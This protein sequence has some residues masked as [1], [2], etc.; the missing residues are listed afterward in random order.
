MKRQ[1]K[2]SQ[3]FRILFLMIA[4]LVWASAASAQI[5]VHG[6][7]HDVHG[8]AIIGA[9][10][11]EHGTTNGTITDLDGNFSLTVKNDSK[12]QISYIGYETQVVNVQ[13]NLNITLSENNKELDEVV[14]IGYGAVK[15]SDATGS[16]ATLEADPKLKGV[17]TTA[18]DMLVGKIAGVNVVNGGGSAN[19]GSTIRI[20][21]GSSLSASNDPLIILDGVYLDNSG[22]GGVGNMLSTIDP[23]DIETFT[24][25][26]DAS[27]TAIYGSR[28]SNG[29]IIITTKK[30][31]A[32]K[33]KI[34]YD[35]NV[36]I[37]KVKKTIDV[38]D[39][40]EYRDFIRNTFKGA[41]N[42]AEVY[43]KAGLDPVTGD[44][45]YDYNTDWQD[46]IY[47]TAVSTEHNISVLGSVKEMMP[48]RVSLGFTDANGVQDGD[49]NRRYTGNIS[50]NPKFLNDRLKLNL[51][52][53]GMII[54]SDFAAGAIG[55]A[56]YYDPTKPIY[57]EGSPYLGYWSWTGIG[58]PY[59]REWGTSYNDAKNN[60]N[61]FG[62]GPNP[63][64]KID[65]NDN[66]ADVKNFIGSAQLEYNFKYVNG[67]KFNYNLS[68]DAS[69]SDGETVNVIGK[70]D[71]FAGSNM[72]DRNEWEQKRR[73]SQMDA[74]L[75]Y[76]HD[77]PSI[78]SKFDVMAGYSWQHYHVEGDS[79]YYAYTPIDPDG[80]LDADNQKFDNDLSNLT[81]NFY[82]NEHYIVSFFGRANYSYND[83][84]LLTFTLRDDGSS[85]FS[86]NNRWGLF[87]S[88]AFA[89]RV[90]QENFMENQNLFSNMKLR[91][92]WGKTGQQDINQGDYPFLST[93]SYS[94]STS[95][96]Y[97]RNGKWV[98][99][100]KPGAYNED[101]KWETT[102]TWNAGLDF[103]MFN[104]RLTA[105]LDYY[106]RETT[107]LINTEAK[108]PSGT[109]FA[110][111][112][113]SNIGTLTNTGVEITLGGM[114]IAKK[115]LQW[116]IDANLAFN[117]NEITKL[118]SGAEDTDVRRFE[119]TSDGDGATT[120]KAHAVNQHAG[121]FYVFQQVY[122]TDGKPIEGAYI[123]RNGDGS[124]NEGDLYFYHN[125]DPKM[126]FGISTKLQYKD[127]DFSI[128]G[129][130]SLGN[131]MYNGVAANSAA[132]APN[133]VY[134]VS[135]LTNKTKSAF[136][137]NFQE[138]QVLSDY[139]IQLASFFRIDNITLGY[140]FSNVFDKIGGRVYF[141]VQNPFVFTKYDGLD[142]EISGGVD[143]SFYPRPVTFLLGLNLNF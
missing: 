53:K 2:T 65:L 74:Y 45:L 135:A 142:P 143:N 64:S 55:N 89:W 10:V 129:H 9:T 13:P 78:K 121:M 114:P 125:A 127:F 16:V 139:Y 120:I 3:H 56:V 110:E 43:T 115:D 15:K 118:S 31:K 128:A 41:S 32:G 24:V 130:G 70:P 46:E 25:L 67:L 132:L 57:A 99:L 21:G 80:A 62:A 22:I 11:V 75:T 97:Y 100:L 138:A 119:R 77:L 29:V 12:I 51:N 106:Y 7:V 95:A 30:G 37:S 123:D 82:E 105:S 116:R 137:T 54:H 81:M 60:Y 63:V 103:G 141:T 90:S 104:D 107:D 136:E 124:I 34:S 94:T 39:G 36:S 19:G 133:S 14:V 8:E 59:D 87:P 72:S 98:S 109:N 20:R 50:L 23:N 33:V 35:G 48:Y 18:D 92:G 93:Y 6:T 66:T 86:K 111:Y 1:S 49:H 42:Q 113:V 79:W 28:A 68:I 69:N 96:S 122:G 84:Y 52:A 88:A 44:A 27:A 85:R 17:A 102:T 91:L 134:A 101:L 76:A 83:R 4:A 131:W 108:T 73:N 58:D 112:V 117:K 38:L 47:R 126:T 140:S 71:L 40:D 61:K 26:K 5:Q